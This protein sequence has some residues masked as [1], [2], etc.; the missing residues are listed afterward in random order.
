MVEDLLVDDIVENEVACDWYDEEDL[1]K[2][3]QSESIGGALN[4]VISYRETGSKDY[5]TANANK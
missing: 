1:T 2:V 5:K 3:I 4:L